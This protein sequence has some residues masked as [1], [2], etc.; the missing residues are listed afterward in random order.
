MA[1]VCCKKKH[2]KKMK[3]R[4]VK[5]ALL[6]LQPFVKINFWKWWFGVE[7]MVG[8]T[9]ELH[10]P[11]EIWICVFLT[12]STPFWSLWWNHLRTRSKSKKL[13]LGAISQSRRDIRTTGQCSVHKNQRWSDLWS[14]EANSNAPWTDCFLLAGKTRRAFHGPHETFVLQTHNGLN[15][16]R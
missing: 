1:S 6:T 11:T 10:L 13:Q 2:N 16:R 14:C 15:F 4:W 12:D 7:Q 5:G 9:R 8:Y 3:L